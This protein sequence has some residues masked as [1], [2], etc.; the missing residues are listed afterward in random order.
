[1]KMYEKLRLY[2]DAG[3]PLIYIHS[4][5]ESKVD[6]IV[7]KSVGGRKIFVWD[8]MYRYRNLKTGEI[9][10]AEYDLNDVLKDGIKYQELDR[11]ILVIKD[12]AEYLDNSETVSLL[13]MPVYRLKKVILIQQL[14]WLPLL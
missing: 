4:F 1:M 12:I 11:K 5:E 6:E 13:K 8:E 10:N 2:L 14:F 7:Q 3:F 9:I